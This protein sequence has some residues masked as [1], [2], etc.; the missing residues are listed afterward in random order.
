M[1]FTVVN[2]ETR[3]NLKYITYCW[4]VLLVSISKLITFYIK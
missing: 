3:V 1:N 2:G 4:A